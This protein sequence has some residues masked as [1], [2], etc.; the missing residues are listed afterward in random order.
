[1]ASVMVAKD[2]ECGSSLVT[3]IRSVS[4]KLRRLDMPIPYRTLLL[5][6]MSAGVIV[7]SKLWCQ[8]IETV[9]IVNENNYD[10]LNTKKGYRMANNT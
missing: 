10:C 6:L 7:K 8:H 5:N 2:V 3:Y 4:P 9:V 1:M